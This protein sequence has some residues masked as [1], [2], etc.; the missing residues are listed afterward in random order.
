MTLSTAGY[1]RSRGGRPLHCPIRTLLI[2]EARQSPLLSSTVSYLPVLFPSPSAHI[3][4][5]RGLHR[6]LQEQVYVDGALGG[7]SA[8]AIGL[9]S[10]LRKTI[11]AS[12]LD[13]WFAN[14]NLLLSSSSD[15][16]PS[17]KAPST[18][19]PAAATLPGFSTLDYSILIEVLASALRDASSAPW[20]WGGS[21]AI[22]SL[23]EMKPS[24]LLD[25]I[26]FTSNGMFG[27]GPLHESMDDGCEMAMAARA[28]EATTAPAMEPAPTL[29]LDASEKESGDE[30][31][32]SIVVRDLPVL[33]F[34]N[35]K[36][37][38]SLLKPTESA[39]SN[40]LLASPV[41]SKGTLLLPFA[42]PSGALASPQLSSED[43]KDPLDK[44]N[45]HAAIL[46]LP[47]ETLA[48]ILIMARFAKD[49]TSCECEQSCPTSRTAAQRW[50]LSLARTCQRFKTPA[51]RAAYN[52]VRL[53]RRN[54][55]TIL[56][57]LI[58]DK[59]ELGEFVRELD[60]KVPGLSV[61][62]NGGANAAHPYLTHPRHGSR[63][64]AAF[65]WLAPV[66]AKC[67]NHLEADDE[68]EQLANL[69][70]ACTSLHKLE[71]NIARPSFA[72]AGWSYGAEF[73]EPGLERALSSE[74]PESCTISR[75]NAVYSQC[76]LFSSH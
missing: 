16:L 41:Q 42:A 7:N 13:E 55:V 40:P 37:L 19:F 53:R 21:G 70:K 64:A 29:P 10:T 63:R 8:A 33:L 2:S 30:A 36:D 5:L 61:A 62:A 12:A 28:A 9:H 23:G 69:V 27:L 59:A 60:I 76:R 45:A 50:A 31:P 72:Y 18:S 44:T 43:D 57:T 11:S 20:L 52:Q 3:R 39:P 54:Q 49:D 74:C 38:V 46:S 68:V 14:P 24:P 25:P 1:Q 34:D 66:Q 26:S 75:A 32:S 4:L 67:A 15:S 48:K 6:G 22:P 73:M 51:Q 65:P 47:D 71:L 35:L 56:L 58:K 17:S